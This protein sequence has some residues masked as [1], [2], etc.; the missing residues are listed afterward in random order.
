MTYPGTWRP[1]DLLFARFELRAQVSVS[2]LDYMPADPSGFCF[3]TCTYS[4]GWTGSDT[5]RI[6]GTVAV[7]YKSGTVVAGAIP[8]PTELDDVSVTFNGV[9]APLHAIVA[10]P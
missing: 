3:R 10:Y 2:M 1:P 9:S 4:Y 6:A 5:L 8:F 7:P